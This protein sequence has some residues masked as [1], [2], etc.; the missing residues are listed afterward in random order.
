[1]GFEVGSDFRVSPVHRDAF[2][3]F[4]FRWI[5]CYDSNKFTGKETGKAHLCAVLGHKAIET[6]MILS[7]MDMKKQLLCV[8]FIDLYSPR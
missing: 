1:M 7:I 5:Y 6:G 2:Y 4:L 8:F 3:Q